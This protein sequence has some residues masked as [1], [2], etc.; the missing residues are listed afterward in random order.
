VGP[1]W[2]REATLDVLQWAVRGL[3]YLP[4]ARRAFFRAAERRVRDAP[5]PDPARARH[6]AAAER[7]KRAMKLALVR[8]A[9]RALADHQLSR[10]SLRGLLKLLLVDVFVRKGD[11]RAKDRFRASHGC[12]PPDFLVLS[13]GKACNLSCVGCYASSGPTR[14]KLDWRTAD[15]IVTDAHDR[16]G[17][18]FFVVS[19]GEPLAWRSDGKDVLDLA[20]RHGDCFFLMYSN[21]TLIDDRVARRFGALGNVIPGLSVEGLRERTDA[22]RGRGVFDKVLAAMG[23]LRREGVLYGLSITATRENAD[24]VLSDELVDLFFGKM[25]AAYA[26]VFHYMPIGRAFTLDLM[27]TPEQR[28]RLWRRVWQLVRERGLFLADFWSSATLSNGCL[29]GGRSGGYFYVDWNGAVSPCVFMPYS[30]V[31]VKDVYARG[32]TLDDV[33]AEP[34]FGAIRR[35]QRD[36]GYRENG[37]EPGAFGNWLRPCLIRDHHPELRRLLEEHRPL[38]V[39]DEARTALADPAYADGLAAFGR[40]L[41]ALMDPVWAREYLATAV[42]PVA[43]AAPRWEP[44]RWGPRPHPRSP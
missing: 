17:T 16:W 36:Y 35:W 22:R 30:P 28:A 14:E 10:A 15:R 44:L 19:G 4:A 42:T 13:P 33:W 1:R 5:L 29:A 18:R 6:P 26:W 43:A 27:L 3:E 25:G 34:F 11:Q 39:D 8:V 7:D 37:E 23:R 2:T 20:G 12:G 40:E 32:G 38:P 41:A 24:E 9:E 21:G 31:N